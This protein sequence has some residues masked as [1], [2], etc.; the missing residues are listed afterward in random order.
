[1]NP[2][3][4]KIYIDKFINGS[5]EFEGLT[6]VPK[7]KDNGKIVW[8]VLNPKNLSYTYNVIYNQILDSLTDFEKL[9]GYTDRSWY[10]TIQSIKSYC[11]FEFEDYIKDDFYKKIYEKISDKVID[12]HL[13]DFK[14]NDGF[15]SENCKVELIHFSF[16]SEIIDM[17]FRIYL[18]K[19]V[20]N[21]RTNDRIPDDEVVDYVS[22]SLQN[23]FNANG[24]F[25]DYLY[26]SL[27]DVT[28]IITNDKR[29]YDFYTT[30][31]NMSSQVYYEGERAF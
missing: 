14:K 27:Q 4:L 17:G 16:D 18:N 2:K 26:R 30:S 31:I 15:Y 1:M 25:I 20:L 11:V 22:E 13:P 12:V 6:I 8:N 28:D 24:E 5:I 19:D 29:I 23:D 10:D 21:S 7:L 9:L 3:I